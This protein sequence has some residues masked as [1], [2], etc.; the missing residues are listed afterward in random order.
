MDRSMSS[1]K[2][3]QRE[4]KLQSKHNFTSEAV[5]GKELKVFEPNFKAWSSAVEGQ[6]SNCIIM[7]VSP[8]GSDALH[9][10]CVL[11]SQVTPL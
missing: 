9:F 5:H 11:Q 10:P 6:S 8:Q 1:E 3:R 4:V 7:W 2:I